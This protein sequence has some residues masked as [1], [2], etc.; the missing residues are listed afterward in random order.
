MKNAQARSRESGRLLEVELPLQADFFAAFT[1]A[2]RA[3][4]AAAIFLRALADIVRFLGIVTTF[5]FPLLALA[6]AHRARCAATILALPAVDILPRRAVPFPYAAPKA[7][8]AAPTA[9]ISLLNRSCSFLNLCTTPPSR[10][11]IESPSR[12]IVAGGR[13][14]MSAIG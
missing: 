7:E 14:R 9:F 1:F 13:G 3:R 4:C 2:H 8:S 5:A 10:F 12:G 11:V 6:F